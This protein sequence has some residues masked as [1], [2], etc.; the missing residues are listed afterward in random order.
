LR[1]FPLPFDPLRIVPAFGS[2]WLTGQ[3]SDNRYAG[4]LQVDPDTGAI[5]RVVRAK[6]ALGTAIAATASALWVGGP[7]IYPQGQPENSGVY[8]L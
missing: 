5:V 1:S 6:R 4:V 3:G 8:L 7:D 2:L